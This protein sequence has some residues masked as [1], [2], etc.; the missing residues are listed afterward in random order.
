MKHLNIH[1]G[2]IAIILFLYSNT[3]NAQSIDVLLENMPNSEV[4]KTK[5]L[6]F[7]TFHMGFTFDENTTEFD[8]KDKENQKQVHKVAKMIAGFKPTVIV[9][10]T[11]PENNTTLQAEYKSYLNNPDMFFKNPSE[12]ELLAYEIGRL[13]GTKRIYGIDHKMGY[14]YRIA[15]QIE[16]TIDSVLINKYYDGPMKFHAQVNVDED[17]LSLLDN[18][19]LTNHDIY[20][21]FLITI[22][23]DI[24]THAATNG[25]F[26]GADEAAK[27]YQRNLRMYSNLNRLD[28][29][30]KDR[31][32]ILMGASHTA[33]FQDFMS[34]SPRYELVNTFDYLK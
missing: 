5:V 31:V 12:I 7:G 14:N 2:V 9:V 15:R 16:N 34:R 18:L 10:E 26:E 1:I 27:Y 28:L 24:L 29:D 25:N 19:K 22:N 6:N 3:T 21:D 8:E 20:L 17:N 33:F 13:S 30:E 11:S 32:F 4:I 23:A